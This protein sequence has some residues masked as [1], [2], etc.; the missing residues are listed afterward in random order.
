MAI[1]MVG[2]SLYY[3]GPAALVLLVLTLALKL[4]WSMKRGE[5]FALLFIGF[6]PL[7]IMVIFTLAVWM[8]MLIDP[9]S[10]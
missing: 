9:A 2:I 8:N 7:I 1:V 5:F 3:L 4:G 10:F 6:S